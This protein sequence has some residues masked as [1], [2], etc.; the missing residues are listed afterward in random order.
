[1]FPSPYKNVLKCRTRQNVGGISIFAFNTKC[2]AEC[3]PHF[4][5]CGTPDQEIVFVV[6]LPARPS[7]VPC[8]LP[9]NE[10]RGISRAMQAN[11]DRCFILPMVGATQSYKCVNPSV[12]FF[13]FPHHF[14]R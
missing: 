11:A 7:L 10:S 6:D 14:Q 9:G 5:A 8:R 3:R 1:M 12:F 13:W 4:A 2:T